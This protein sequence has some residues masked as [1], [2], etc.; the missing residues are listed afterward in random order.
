MFNIGIDFGGVLSMHDSQQTQYDA[1]ND[2][3]N[4]SINMPD[5]M[6]S[7][8]ELSRENNLYLISY[9]GLPR[10]K[11]TFT[12]MKH[13][14]ADIF[15]KK[16]FYTV[17]REYKAQICSYLG[18][19]FMIDDREKV[20][21]NI[22]KHNPNIIT[23]YFHSDP[24]VETHNISP[25]HKTAKHWKDVLKIINE[26]NYFNIDRDERIDVSMYLHDVTDGKNKFKKDKSLWKGKYIRAL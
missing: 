23:I 4:T 21:E 1:G 11:E 2:H 5:A 10:A 9:C 13:S 16:Q 3:I 6:E 7:L 14:G 19:H 18:C 20:L 25:H 22:R 15:F 12:G 24:N 8:E 17:K 26:T